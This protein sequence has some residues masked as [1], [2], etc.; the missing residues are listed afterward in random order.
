MIGHAIWQRSK[1]RAPS[2]V[3]R[4]RSRRRPSRL[5]SGGDSRS[6]LPDG[7]HVLERLVRP[8]N[9]MYGN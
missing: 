3:P 5:V 4:A 9:D 7:K 6:R 1:T 2:D 8:R